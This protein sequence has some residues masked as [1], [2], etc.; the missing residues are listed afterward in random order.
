MG[1]RKDL[2]NEAYDGG[3]ITLGAVAVSVVSKKI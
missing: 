1:D 3:L 2:M